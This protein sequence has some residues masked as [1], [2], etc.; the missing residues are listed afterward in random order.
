MSDEAHFHLLGTVNKQNFRYWF[1]TNPQQLRM[2]PLHSPRVTV[3][4][5]VVN[6]GIIGLYYFQ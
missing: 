4:C 3:R 2:R 6:F 1:N 5:A